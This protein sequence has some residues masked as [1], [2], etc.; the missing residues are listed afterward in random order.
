MYNICDRIKDAGV[1]LVLRHRTKYHPS[2]REKMIL[3]NGGLYAREG[4]REREQSSCC[5]LMTLLGDSTTLHPHAFSSLVFA[6]DRDNL[7]LAAFALNLPAK[8]V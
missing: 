6:S 7:S 2:K 3:V 5:R 1:Q 4:E 8:R